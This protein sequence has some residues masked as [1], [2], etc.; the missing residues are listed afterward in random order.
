M[1][2]QRFCNVAPDGWHGSSST[3][4]T[5]AGEPPVAQIAHVAFEQQRLE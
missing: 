5:Q 1:A 4:T 2:V 3:L